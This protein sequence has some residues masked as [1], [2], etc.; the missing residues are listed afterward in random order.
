MLLGMIVLL[1][2]LA[3]CSSDDST[4][5]LAPTDTTSPSLVTDLRVIWANES[6]VNL[7]WTSVGDDEQ[8]GTAQSYE[9]RMA[10]YPT[11]PYGWDD[12]DLITLNGKPLAAGQT[13]SHAVTGLDQDSVHV[14]RL[15]VRDEAGNASEISLPVIATT[16]TQHDSTAPDPIT[17]LTIW[18]SDGS[19]LEVSWTA[20]GDD[21]ALGQA[22]SYEVRYSTELITPANWDAATSGA[23]GASTA[24]GERLNAD[25]N[26]LSPDTVYHLAV[27]MS[28]E[29][30]NRSLLSNNLVAE[31]V[32][33]NT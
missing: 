24:T 14:F 10:L 16:A 27:R 18:S 1:M 26:S 25:I 8:T 30:G 13:Q 2:A 17:D 23:T 19:H 12:W 21:G 28:D 9:L 6:T 11:D 7:A 3:G 15:V 22:A 32:V 4:T 33:K 29:Q 20:S 31:T 5:L